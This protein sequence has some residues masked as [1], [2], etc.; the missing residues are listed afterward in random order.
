M[1]IEITLFP[2]KPLHDRITLQFCRLIGQEDGKRRPF[3][4]AKIIHKP[5]FLG[6]LVNVC[7]D[8]PELAVVFDHNAPKWVLEQTACSSIRLI[9]RFGIGV[10]EVGKLRLAYVDPKGF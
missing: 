3:P 5:M 1:Q 10:V 7:N 6:I 4:I 9:D 8:A 2:A